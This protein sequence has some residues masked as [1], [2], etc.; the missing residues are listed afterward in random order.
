MQ[1]FTE[2]V[3]NDDDTINVDARTDMKKREKRVI[4][5]QLTKENHQASRL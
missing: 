4:R 2:A 1:Y 5:Q 3:N